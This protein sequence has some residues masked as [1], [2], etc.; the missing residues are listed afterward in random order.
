M[1]LNLIVIMMTSLLVLPG[2][3]AQ[4][5]RGNFDPAKMNMEITVNGKVFNENTKDPVEY[6]NVILVSKR[7]STLIF[8]NV[9]DENGIFSIEKVRPGRYA[10]DVQFMGFGKK[11]IDMIAIRPD[12]KIFE[13]GEIYLKPELVNLDEVVVEA[14]RV[15]VAFQIDKKVINV[16]SQAVSASG[17][18]IDVLENVPSV[19]V[20]IEGNVS[21]RGSENFTVLVDGRPTILEPTEILQQL[22][23]SKIE[24]IEIITNPS[25]KFDPD[26]VAGIVNVVMKK[27]KIEGISGIL[28]LNGGLN[29]K[30]GLDGMFAY[31]NHKFAAFASADYSHWEFSGERISERVTTDI[32]GNTFSTISEGDMNH[33]REPYSFRVGLDLYLTDR[34]MLTLGGTYGNRSGERISEM[35]YEEMSS[36]DNI[37]KEYLS[38]DKSERSGDY[39]RFNL[40]YQHKFNNEG[41]ELLGQFNYSGSTGDEESENRLET[42]TESTSVAQKSLE[43]GPGHDYRIKLDYTWPINPT[44]KLEAGFQSRIDISDEDNE[45]FYYDTRSGQYEYQEDFSHTTQYKNNIHSVYTMYSL[46]RGR[47]GLQGGLR[48]EYTDRKIELAGENEEYVIDR[49]DFFPSAHLSWKQTE[50]TQIMGSYTRRIERPR[51]HWLEPF[52]TWQ[53]AYTVRIGNP[54]IK[55]EYIDSYELSFLQYFGKNMISLEAYRRI[56]NNKVER[57]QSV[58]EEADDVILHTIANVGKDYVFGT[59]FMFRMNLLRW[60][61]LNW[62]GNLYDYRIKGEYGEMA[63]DNHSFNWNMRLNSDFKFSKGTTFQ[64]NTGYNSP[65]VTAQGTREGD[66]SVNLAVKQNFL[67]NKLTTTLQVRDVFGTGKR[68]STTETDRLYSYNYMERE[69]P[70][71]MLNLRYNFNNFREKKSDRQGMD[72]A[73]EGFD[74]EDEF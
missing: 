59:E 6:A 42:L 41:H 25:A 33:T 3:N 13:I 17:T 64:I 67:Q 26:G 28:N 54:D 20:D 48:S 63:F 35:V 11:R 29:Q 69:A 15:S 74:S 10:L 49:L 71:V 47:L 34:D 1:R 18:A 14:D 57:V 52:I 2:L 45:V 9:T 37:K 23:A 24:N 50:T 65:T 21:L 43:G 53:D 56:N 72:D 5:R 68:E 51:G 38:I 30:Y 66:F 12:S 55:P 39:F 27:N 22:P 36:I 8:G 61:T 19:T 58:Y 60:W 4:Q 44:D 40:D 16:G 46:E 7:D 73:N 32:A 70:M 31:R 62:M